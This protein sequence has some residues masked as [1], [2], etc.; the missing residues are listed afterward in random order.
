ML[1]VFEIF[2]LTA[3]V[4]ANIV[5]SKWIGQQAYS[6]MPL[7]AT[8]EAKQVDICSASW[9]RLGRSSSLGLLALFCIRSLPVGHLEE[10]GAMVTPPGV[11]GGLK[12]SGP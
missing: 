3:I 9:L 7:Q 4:A 5:A 6:W 11:I 12:P 10:T 2:L 8:A 1:R